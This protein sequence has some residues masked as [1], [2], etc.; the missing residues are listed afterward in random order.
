METHFP[1]WRS[2]PALAAAVAIVCGAL[3]GE[4]LDLAIL[5]VM[6]VGALGA[7]G[8]ART[9]W[10]TWLAIGIVAARLEIGSG[11]SFRIDPGRPVEARVRV[12]E[13]PRRGPFGW[14][15]RARTEALRQGVTVDPRPRDVILELPADRPVEVGEVWRVRGYLARGSGYANRLAVEAGPERLRVKTRQLA[16]LSRRAS[17]I[18]RVSA[19]L[20]AS[21]DRALA[22]GGGGAGEA[23]ARAWVLGDLTRL[24]AP[25][26]RAMQRA[27]LAHLLA[28]SGFNVSLAAALCW[29][30][31]TW[32]PGRWR[33]LPPLFAIV[34]YLLLVGPLAPI[35]RAALMALLALTALW[36]RRPPHAANA[37]AVTVGGLVLAQPGV[38]RD[39]GFQLTVAATAGLIFL[40][41]RLERAW[42]ALPRWLRAPL[43]AS[44]AAQLATLPFVLAA[45]H[46]LAP[47]GI[48]ANLWAVPWS[49]ACL[50]LALAWCGLS[51][52]LPPWGVATAGLL[53]GLALPFTALADT[54]ASL[55]QVQPSGFG[56]WVGALAATGLAAACLRPRFA[57]MLAAVAALGLRCAPSIAGAPSLTFFD[58]GQG[59]AILVRDGR[60]ALL[61]DGGGWSQGDFGGRVL[62]PALAGEGI[63]RLDAVALTHP[64]R[65]HCGGLLD[66]VDYIEIGELWMAPDQA[67]GCARELRLRPGPKLRVLWAGE[68]ARLAGWLLRVLSPSAAPSGTD[69]GRSLVLLAETK[70]TRALLTGDIEAAGEQELLGAEALAKGVDILKVAHHGSQTSSAAVFLRAVR[71]RL[72]VISVGAGNAFGH[73]HAAVLARLR[74]AGAPTLRTDL[75]GEVVVSILGG[76]S[77]RVTAPGAPR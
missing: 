72:A 44:A 46:Q 68:Q 18:M 55:W 27:G 31:G 12:V 10:L 65:D 9:R 36:L 8:G 54:P 75:A 23:F 43:A 48:V 63:R 37:L 40:S 59:D 25:W 74:S 52:L 13:H 28:V 76:G 15:V 21:V 30:L 70:G 34:A 1:D 51:M 19:R 38:V 6:A 42:L 60:H 58:V 62:V 64:D 17:S 5:P 53:D 57:W 24:E 22:R 11:R 66:L 32:L 50:L 16:I 47:M 56:L 49:A 20:R 3:L 29:Y 7:A 39:V 69:N 71:P 33:Y 77:L 35:L 67:A 4:R 26:R 73:P 45:F 2:T 14:S 41:P 61:V